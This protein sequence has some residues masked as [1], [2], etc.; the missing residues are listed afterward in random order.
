MKTNGL[1]IEVGLQLIKF[2]IPLRVTYIRYSR[3]NY[4]KLS[5]R[6]LKQIQ[7]FFRLPQQKDCRGI[8]EVNDV[9]YASASAK[10]LPTTLELKF[11]RWVSQVLL[12]NVFFSVCKHFVLFQHCLLA[13]ISSFTS[14]SCRD[15]IAVEFKHGLP[16]L[17]VGMILRSVLIALE[18]LHGMGYVHRYIHYYRRRCIVRI[19]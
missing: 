12:N 3:G 1:G 13:L 9:F 5:R 6:L 17:V 4:W 10:R 16:F 7:K 14:G 2:V 8:A 19:V 18:Y 11:E 15:V